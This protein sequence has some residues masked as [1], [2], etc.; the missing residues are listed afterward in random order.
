MSKIQNL[1]TRAQQTEGSIQLD[2]VVHDLKSSE[3]SDIN[4]QGAKAQIEYIVEALGEEEGI[5]R[6][7]A[8]LDE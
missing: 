3:A 7:E 1:I 6:I 5:K 4:N 8:A 2:D